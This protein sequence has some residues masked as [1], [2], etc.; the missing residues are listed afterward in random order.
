M[1]RSEPVGY[2]AIARVTMPGLVSLGALSSGDMWLFQIMDV[3]IVPQLAG[4]TAW[5]QPRPTQ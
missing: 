5:P 2:H 1:N 4:P 3:M